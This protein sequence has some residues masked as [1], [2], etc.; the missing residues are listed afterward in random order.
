M[1]GQFQPFVQTRCDLTFPALIFGGLFIIAT[2]A[3]AFDVSP[4]VG[5]VD[6][7]DVKVSV[8]QYTAAP[9]DPDFMMMGCGQHRDGN[10]FPAR[11]AQCR[12]FQSAKH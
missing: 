8:D 11:P 6:L 10:G 7:E 3:R 9:I 1:T 4:M 12:K 2:A 5:G